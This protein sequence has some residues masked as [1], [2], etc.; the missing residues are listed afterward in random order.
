MGNNFILDFE[1]DQKLR[2]DQKEIPGCFQTPESQK[3][4]NSYFNQKYLEEVLGCGV[5]T[6]V[7]TVAS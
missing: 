5:G 4:A 7:S 6:T 1:L 3:N 2:E